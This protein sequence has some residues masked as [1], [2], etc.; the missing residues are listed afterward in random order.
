MT[1]TTG[2]GER[3]KYQAKEAKKAK[4]QHKK[5][6]SPV[7][8][9]S[10]DGWLTIGTIVAPQGLRGEMRVYPDTDFPERFEE[11][12]K[13]WL[14]RNNSQQPEP[15]ELTSGRYLDGKNLYVI[16]LKGINNCDQVEELRGCQLLVPEDDRPPLGENEYHI[17]DLIGLQVFMQ[18]S[19]DY[20][21]KIVRL[22][23]AG[24][25]LLE[26]EPQS[27]TTQPQKSILIPFVREIVPL[28][29]LAAKRVEITPP[30][31]L[32]EIND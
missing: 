5:S 27:D 31:G 13:R 17:V 23:P 11:P 6:F 9:S 16:R 4:K 30:E 7:I 12:G 15:V 26:I 10:L 28:V 14:L 21:G 20:I 24:N 22:I 3:K 32:L 19:G 2:N 8:S 29:D 18:T 25:Y 1:Q